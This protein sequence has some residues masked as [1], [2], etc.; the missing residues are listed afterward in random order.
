MENK[1]TVIDAKIGNLNE[2]TKVLSVKEQ[3]QEQ[4]LVV[5]KALRIGKIVRNLKFEK[6]QGY[7]LTSLF[8]SLLIMRLWGKTIASATS[9]HFHGLCTVSK[10]TLYRA[11]LNARIDWRMLLTKITLRF[12]AIL[13][14]HQVN[15]DEHDTCAILDDTT[16]QKSGIRIEGVSKVFDHVTHSFIYGMKC[17]TLALSDGKSCY[18]IDFSLHRE[19]GKK[20]DYGLTLKQ[21]KEQF[22]EK[23]NA[24]NPDY[25]RKA[26]C[27]E[28]KLEMAKRMLCHAVEYGI[29]FKYV[30]ADSWFTC[31]SL[32][33]AVR[34]LCGGSV[35]YIGLAKMNPKLRYQTSKSKHSQ[36]IHE[37]I[38]RYER[39]ASCYCRKYKCK[40]I[41]L[42][43]KMGEQPI[44]IFIIKYGRSTH[45]KVLLTTDTSMNFVRAFE[46]YERRWGIEV[47][48]K[49]CRGYLGLGKCQS[50]SYNAQ[51]ADTTLCFMMYQ[52]LSLAK[53]FSEY[54]TLGALFRSERD[55][56]QVLTLWSRTLEE[57]RHLLEVLSREAGV[58][59]LACLSTVA[60]RQMADFSTKV[61]AH[62]LCDSDDYAMPDLD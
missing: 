10:N 52:M 12:H 55:R 51:I 4:L 18:P 24:K 32:I 43:A 19:K 21:R 57:V 7:T 16:F 59:L 1:N 25:A 11:L 41:Q 42:N 54:E 56:L 34:E 14:E 3:A 27:D 35:H 36:N 60:A 44:R 45:W 46:L 58:D 40:Y 38:V 47:I 6:A 22:K 5:M 17:L 23:R 20:K 8:I 50:R 13:R 28:S 39:T 2:L 33:Q 49:E 48:F 31:E 30:L 26:E 61:W 62:L 15:T 29:N 9:N 37:L 53:R